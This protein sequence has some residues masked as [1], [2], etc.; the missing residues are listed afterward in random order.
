MTTFEDEEFF[1]SFY[2]EILYYDDIFELR[3]MLC[4]IFNFSPSKNVIFTPNITTSLN[5]VIK[6]LLTPGDHWLVSSLEHNAVM[7]PL[8]QI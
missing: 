2:N 4:Q 3:E 6:G 8:T 7:R 1:I 5:Y